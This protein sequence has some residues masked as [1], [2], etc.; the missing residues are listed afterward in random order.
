MTIDEPTPVWPDGLQ[1]LNFST[2]DNNGDAGYCLFDNYTANT[3]L[4]GGYSAS[5]GNSTS[6]VAHK[7][8]AISDITL[9]TTWCGATNTSGADPKS[10]TLPDVQDLLSILH[11]EKLR[12]ATLINGVNDGDTSFASASGYLQNSLIRTDVAE[13]AD[14]DLNSCADGDPTC[15]TTISSRYWSSE[16]CTVSTADD[17][18]WVLD[19]AS[20][21]LSCILKTDTALVRPVYK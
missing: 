12:A 18:Q 17:G 21:Q 8:L 15:T 16:V 1:S 13:N 5:Q 20:A 9:P 2:A 11:I 3:W 6:Y 14:P 4:I 10:W 19:F 7:P